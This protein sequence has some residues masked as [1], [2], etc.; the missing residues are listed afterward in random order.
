MVL[1]FLAVDNFD[2][3]RKN[4]QK[5]FGEKLVKM[6]GFCQNWI[7][8]EKF[9][10]L[11]SV[12]YIHSSLASLG[13]LLLMSRAKLRTFRTPFFTN[14]FFAILCIVLLRLSNKHELL[15][16][17]A[18]YPLHCSAVWE[19]D[20]ES[21]DFATLWAKRA[22]WIKILAWKFKACKRLFWLIFNHCETT[23]GKKLFRDKLLAQ[24][25]SHK[26]QMR[27]TCQTP[28]P[29]FRPLFGLG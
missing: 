14:F 26:H 19:N 28:K 29:Y 1:D 21:L 17:K 10:F 9:D 23:F 18:T 3:T 11:N 13:L 5:I 4:V 15:Y 2:F 16:L 24:V 8:G 6:F 22:Y 12:S 7:F 20:L 27:W 25:S